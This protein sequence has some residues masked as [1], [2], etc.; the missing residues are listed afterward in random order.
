MSHPRL[1]LIEASFHER[2]VKLRLPFR[3]GVVTLT[4]APQA[5]VRARVALAD[6]REGEGVAAELLVPKWFDKSPALSNDD[7]FNQLRRSLLTAG[8]R[9]R[10]AGLHS[11]F[12]L[13]AAVEAEHHAACAK[14]GLNGLVASFGLALIERAII[15]ALG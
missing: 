12:A 3:F 1:C 2:P 6:G 9:L 4:E 13:S 10:D 7:N 11:P 8:A 14:E 15:D 5:F